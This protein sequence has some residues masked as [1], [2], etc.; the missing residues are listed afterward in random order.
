MKEKIIKKIYY[1]KFMSKNGIKIFKSSK[2]INS[3]RKNISSPKFS[4]NLKSCSNKYA[5]SSSN[6]ILETVGD[7]S[8]CVTNTSNNKQ[9][10]KRKKEKS[11]K[12]RRSRDISKLLKNK[13]RIKIPIGKRMSNN[14]YNIKLNLIN[15]NNN[16]SE[17][18]KQPIQKIK[19]RKDK[20]GIEINKINKKKVH[21]TFIDNIPNNK[22]L[23]EEIPILSYKN[24]NFI[25]YINKDENNNKCGVCCFIF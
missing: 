19:V 8:K 1:N 24:Y 14:N 18:N 22:R 6:N 2:S 7:I 12:G 15:I 11:M 20:N 21:I 5:S 23:V 25:N 10:K 9:Q 4:N 13:E 17:S 3:F 16:N